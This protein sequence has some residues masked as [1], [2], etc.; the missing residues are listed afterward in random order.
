[1]TFPFSNFTLFSA[2]D[3]YKLLPND[4]SFVFDFNKDG[5]VA[6]RKTFPALVGSGSAVAAA[7]LGGKS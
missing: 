5:P 4:A 7:Q 2:S 1:M 3:R 6:N